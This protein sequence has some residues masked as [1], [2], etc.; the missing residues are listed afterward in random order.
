MSVIRL[1]AV[2]MLLTI[3]SAVPSFSQQPHWLVGTWK[4][5]LGGLSTSAKYGSD[6]TLTISAVAADGASANAVW[7]GPGAKQ[8]V[9]LT[10]AGD[11]VNFSTPTSQGSDYKLVHKGNKLEGVW[12]GTGTGKS[13]PV[14]LTKQ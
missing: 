4:G 12:Q 3:A 11:N 14:S 10:I 2:A 1:I 6:R 9:K 13:G 8:T 7:E 5:E